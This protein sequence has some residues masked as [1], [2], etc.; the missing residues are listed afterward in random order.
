MSIF[1]IQSIY[2]FSCV[3]KNMSIAKQ[4]FDMRK[5]FVTVQLNKQMSYYSDEAYKH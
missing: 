4:M 2:L 3:S 5:H 1:I